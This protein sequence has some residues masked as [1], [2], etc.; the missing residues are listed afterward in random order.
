[1]NYWFKFALYGLKELVL[2]VFN[3]DLGLGF[4]V[5]DLLLASSVIG[6]V[7]SA[8]IVKSAHISS[9]DSRINISGGIGRKGDD[10]V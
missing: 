9:G 7:G 8:L 6:V 2:M 4:S 10:D 5:G 1:M 3:W